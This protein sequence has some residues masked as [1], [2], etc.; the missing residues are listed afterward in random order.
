MDQKGAKVAM[1]L[2]EPQAPDSLL[3]WG[4]FNAIFEQKEYG[5][6]YVLEQLAREMLDK[7][8]QLRADYEKRLASDPKLAPV[9]ERACSS[10]ISAHHIGIHR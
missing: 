1:N 4:F 7:D 5:E 6:N 10:F 3:A 2:L 8:P 9:R